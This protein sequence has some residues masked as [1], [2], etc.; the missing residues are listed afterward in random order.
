MPPV[1]ER[2]KHTIAAQY[3]QG[4]KPNKMNVAIYGYNRYVREIIESLRKDELIN[5]HL[6]TKS[7]IEE[8][9]AV[10]DNVM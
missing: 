1:V 9:R 10:I 3:E 8:R 2:L 4:K 6:V 7:V 5:L